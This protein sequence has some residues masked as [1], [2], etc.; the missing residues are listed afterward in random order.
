MPEALAPR[1]IA[2]QYLERALTASLADSSV[3]E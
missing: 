2:S 1:R 3:P